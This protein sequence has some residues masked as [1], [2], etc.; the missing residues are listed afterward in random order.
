VGVKPP[1]KGT[2][3]ELRRSAEARLAQAG[4]AAPAASPSALLHELQ[5][6]QVE[7][8]LQNDELR[9]TQGELELAHARYLALY[10]FAPVGYFSVDERGCLT[11]INL[12][13][14]AML[15]GERA[16]LLGR[17]F[18]RFV[19]AQDLA[20]WERQ[21][22]QSRLPGGARRCELQLQPEGRKPFPVELICGASEEGA[23]EPGG[24]KWALLDITERYAAEAEREQRL[25]E[26]L[27]LNAQLKQAQVHLL[28]A[29]KLSAIGQ[30]AAG[31]AHEVNNPLTYVKSN[32]CMTEERADEV[33]DALQASWRAEEACGT[34]CLPSQ[35][36][37]RVR[38]AFDLDSARRDL[39]EMVGESLGGL[40]RVAKLVHDLRDFAHPDTGK[41]ETVE[42]KSILERALRLIEV[43]QTGK[44]N[45]VRAF[46]AE[47][48]RL[49][50]RPSQLDQVF[51]NLLLNA[52]Q[53]GGPSVTVTLRT[54]GIGAEAW[55]EIEDDGPG[56]PAESLPRLFEPFFTTKPIGEGT[57]L[58]LSV[59]HGI[60]RSHGGRI[61]VKSR[62]GSG[63]TFRVVLPV[64][65]PPIP[66]M[67]PPLPVLP[68]LGR[69]G[70]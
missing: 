6:H 34:A 15:G 66:V 22:K 40:D 58:G 47:A 41:L 54:G 11:S 56:I 14:A 32:I 35:E 7:L 49:R 2:V 65:G 70:A 1:G 59:A 68:G 69:Y 30:L 4:T 25:A 27:R 67:A 50:C 60:V 36:L 31:M 62:V 19:A 45:F 16:G 51:M 53:A 24:T 48:Q 20:R 18:S 8:E 13:G 33:L 23:T 5:V 37:R 28:Q 17:P 55:A 9:R 64:D 57:G 46:G 3:E 39:K 12:A 29:D 43:S 21:W 63:T 61:E 38:E 52:A 44:A 10:D 26:L 42:L